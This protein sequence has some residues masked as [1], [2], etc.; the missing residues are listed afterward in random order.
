MHGF[1]MA[2][3]PRSDRCGSETCGWQAWLATWGRG[4]EGSTA[5]DVQAG[6]LRVRLHDGDVLGDL[7]DDRDTDEEANEELSA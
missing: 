5:R 6:R 1:S 3:V 4:A 7:D 2:P